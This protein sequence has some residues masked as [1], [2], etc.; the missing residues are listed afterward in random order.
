MNLMTKAIAAKLFANDQK[1]I[2]SGESPDEIVVKYFNPCGAQ[3]WYMVS[4]TPL[5]AVNGE[6]VDNPD[7]AKDWHLFGF[8]NLGDDLN[9]E[10]GYLLLSELEGTKL[11][12]GLGI[13]RDL[14]YDGHSLK[15][16]QADTRARA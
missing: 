12:A 5:D 16:V 14:Y 4:G 13:E 8:C 6:P 9:A 11:P 15:Q 7:D 10:L 3:T 2:E 1:V